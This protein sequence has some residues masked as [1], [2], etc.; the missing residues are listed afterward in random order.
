METKQGKYEESFELERSNAFIAA[1]QLF[2]DKEVLEQ[3]RHAK[4]SDEL[5]RIMASARRRI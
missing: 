2:Y 4:D 1:K 5:R 3:I